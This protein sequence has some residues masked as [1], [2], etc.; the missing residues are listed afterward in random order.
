MLVTTVIIINMPTDIFWKGN[1][2]SAGIFLSQVTLASEQAR[3]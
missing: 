2:S 1:L 3:P